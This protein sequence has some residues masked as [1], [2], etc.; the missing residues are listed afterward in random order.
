MPA[1]DPAQIRQHASPENM[2]AGAV[3]VEEQL[4]L[5][6]LR[7]GALCVLSWRER[8]IRTCGGSAGVGPSSF[9]AMIR[10]ALPYLNAAVCGGKGPNYPA[11]PCPPSARRI[12]C[13]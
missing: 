8:R 11:P 1:E 13:L 7:L 9:S 5:A 3:P 6:T 4:A 10:P 12:A 2:A